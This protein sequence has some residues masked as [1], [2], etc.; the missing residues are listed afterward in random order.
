MDFLRAKIGD[1]YEQT[2]LLVHQLHAS[3]R[4][5]RSVQCQK[6]GRHERTALSAHQLRLAKNRQWALL[7]LRKRCHGQDSYQDEESQVCRC[8]M[9]QFKVDAC[10]RQKR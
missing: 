10:F 9:L 6:A 2:A 3:K 7:A 1:K 5:Q 8:F 4:R